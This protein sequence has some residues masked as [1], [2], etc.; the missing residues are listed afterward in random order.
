MKYE[1]FVHSHKLFYSMMTCIFPPVPG[2]KIKGF[3]S[4]L[5]EVSVRSKECD[6]T[7]YSVVISLHMPAQSSSI[8]PGPHPFPVAPPRQHVY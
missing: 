3:D 5:L 4:H 1:S 6:V 7:H 8:Q 2:P